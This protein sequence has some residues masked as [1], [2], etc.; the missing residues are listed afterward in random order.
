M[1]TKHNTLLEQLEERVAV[2][3]DTYDADFIATLSIVPH[4]ATSNQGFIHA[5]LV[6]GRNV[7]IV[8]RTVRELKGQSWEN[9]YAVC[10]SAIRL[11]QPSDA[12]E[13]CPNATTLLG[14]VPD[15]LPTD[16]AP[17]LHA[18]PQRFF[19]SYRVACSSKY[20]H[21]TP[22]VPTTSLTMRVGTLAHSTPNISPSE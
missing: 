14:A 15:D 11:Y 4:D 12:L 7:D 16:A 1:L 20:R 3:A 18:S 9:V 2:D 5:A 6:D 10:V 8:E 17:R 22:T 21:V 19:Q 13:K